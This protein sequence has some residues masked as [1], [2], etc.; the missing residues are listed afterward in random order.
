VSLRLMHDV[1]FVSANPCRPPHGHALRT[2]PDR[3]VHPIHQHGEYLPSHPL[4]QTYR[5]VLKA[6]QDLVSATPPNPHDQKEAVWIVDA[7]RSR[8]KDI[9]VR[10]WCSQVGRHAIMSRVGKTCLS[11]SIREA[12]AIEV[13]VIIRV[14]GNE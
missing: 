2:T 12:K 4:H 6:V 5:Y 8:E 1:Y 7:R 9:F 11:C 10:A 14:G 13:A 3:S